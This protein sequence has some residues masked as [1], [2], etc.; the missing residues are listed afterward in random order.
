M[1]GTGA[2]LVVDDES[3]LLT[4]SET[5]LSEFG[6][7]VVTA[8]NAQKALTTIPGPAGNPGGFLILT[9]Y[10]SCPAWAGAS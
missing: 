8:N 10:S 9:D 4:M 5:V 1:R 3:L 2:I 7:T 6:Y